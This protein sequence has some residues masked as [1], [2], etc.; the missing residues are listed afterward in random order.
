M[1]SSCVFMNAVI[2]GLVTPVTWR[3]R[4]R[5]SHVIPPGQIHLSNAISSFSLVSLLHFGVFCLP[6]LALESVS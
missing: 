6:E 3:P 4:T 2:L 5:R 1:M